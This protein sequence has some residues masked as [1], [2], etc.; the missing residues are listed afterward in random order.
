MRL[1]I[2]P[3]ECSPLIWNGDDDADLVVANIWSDYVSVLKN[4]GEGT[5]GAR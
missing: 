3:S 1:G 4:N 5:F 2:C